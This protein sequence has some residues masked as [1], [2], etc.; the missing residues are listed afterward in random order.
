MDKK[1]SKLVGDIGNDAGNNNDN[2][3]KDIREDR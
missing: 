3:F 1:K 2:K